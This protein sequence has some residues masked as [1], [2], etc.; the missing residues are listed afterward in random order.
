MSNLKYNF[1]KNA[2]DTQST[3]VESGGKHILGHNPLQITR[4]Q[5]IIKILNKWKEHLTVEDGNKHFKIR[6]PTGKLITTFTKGTFG[7][8][9]PITLL[10]RLRDHL[11]NVGAYELKPGESK[12]LQDRRSNVVVEPETKPKRTPEEN[13][14]RL[15][16]LLS[17]QL[18]R[19]GEKR[20]KR[21]QYAIKRTRKVLGT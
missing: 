10:T 3:I 12:G 18:Q 1:L 5:Q 17:T 16:T 19:F 11:V 15:K 8:K 7:P 14:E 4:A 21:V 6:T 9:G 2:I 20:R 13:K